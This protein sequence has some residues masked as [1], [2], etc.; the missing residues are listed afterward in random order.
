MT[1]TFISIVSIGNIAGLK[2]VIS[3]LLICKESEAIAM[4]KQCSPKDTIFLNEQA[5]RLPV[6]DRSAVKAF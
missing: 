4:F 6:S 2:N 1:D 3:F 5:K